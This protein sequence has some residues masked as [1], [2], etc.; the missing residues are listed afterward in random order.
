MYNNYQLPSIA[1]S[2]YQ[3]SGYQSAWDGYGWNNNMQHRSDCTCATCAYQQHYRP[4][5]MASNYSA[6]TVMG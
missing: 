6:Q 2:Y 3:S 4:Y 5:P 1:N